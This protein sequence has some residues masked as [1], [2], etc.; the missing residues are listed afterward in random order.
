MCSCASWRARAASSISR[1][2]CAWFS[3][4][5]GGRIFSATWALWPSSA[6]VGRLPYLAHAA[7]RDRALEPVAPLERADFLARH[8]ADLGALTRRQGRAR[9]I[10]RY[11]GRQRIGRVQDRVLAAVELLARE[12][13]VLV[14]R[15]QFAQLVDRRLHHPRAGSAAPQ[16][17]Q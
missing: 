16:A 13:A 7:V 5:W 12:Q 17:A 8:Q 15:A 14:Q 4:S 11:A 10:G 9:A 6:W 1:R 3:V 2:A